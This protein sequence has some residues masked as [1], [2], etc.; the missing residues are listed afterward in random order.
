ME[1]YTYIQTEKE[2]YVKMH[3][4]EMQAASSTKR[5]TKEEILK[6]LH[7]STQHKS[8]ELPCP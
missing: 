6:E 4:A 1:T 7:P 3:E 2:I 5:Y 8:V